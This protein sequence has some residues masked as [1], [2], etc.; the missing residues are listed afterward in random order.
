MSA[1]QHGL[2]GPS[3]KDRRQAVGDPGR[4]S[5]GRRPI[6]V[7]DDGSAAAI[8]AAARLTGGTL[9]ECTAAD[10]PR[11][12][13]LQTGERFV[14]ASLVWQ[15]AAARGIAVFN[16]LS[17]LDSG[18]RLVL[19]RMHGGTWGFWAGG[20]ARV[21]QRYVLPGDMFVCADGAGLSLRAAPDFHAPMLAV[22]PDGTPVTGEEFVLTEPGTYPD[23]AGAGWYRLSAPQPGWV[24]SRFLLDARAPDC[25]LLPLVP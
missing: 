23:V 14:D 16:V 21:V 13:R 6:G 12:G 25:S 5:S 9:G 20:S 7:A 10:P 15:E 22:L 11:T 24:Y 4:R 3:C 1:G 2:L 17:C 19:G 18:E 8:A